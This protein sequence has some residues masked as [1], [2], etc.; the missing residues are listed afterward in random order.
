MKG[1]HFENKINNIN[2]IRNDNNDN[3]N[4]VNDNDVN[5]ILKKTHNTII[6]YIFLIIIMRK[7]ND[8]S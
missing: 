3:N 5:E 4:N 8:S 6:I 2:S 7:V 1:N